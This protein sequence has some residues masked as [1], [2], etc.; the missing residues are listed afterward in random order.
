MKDYKQIKSLIQRLEKK[1]KELNTLKS[2]VLKVEK[3][4]EELEK[5]LQEKLEFSNSNSNASF[6]QMN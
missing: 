5:E 6:V 4:I 3:E 2:K 1:Q